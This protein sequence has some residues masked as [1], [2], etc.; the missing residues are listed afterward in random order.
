M[1]K[2][3]LFLILAI[4]TFFTQSAKS[5]EIT[6][7]SWDN[8]EMKFSAPKEFIV[9][10]NSDEE[11][12]AKLSNDLLHLSIIP[13]KDA[14]LTPESLKN[15][16]RKLCEEMGYT[17]REIGT[18]NDI[19]LNGFTGSYCVITK[20]GVTLIVE[21]LLDQHGETNFYSIIVYAGEY[22]KQAYAIANSF[23]K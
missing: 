18:I 17:P 2:L 15:S 23:H 16:V 6:S 22:E 10:T 12:T 9:Q 13:W 20:N 5:Q 14:T 11:F 7:W 1:K 21:G 3:K 4:V 19:D 8:Y